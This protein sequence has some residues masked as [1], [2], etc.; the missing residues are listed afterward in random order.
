MIILRFGKPWIA[1]LIPDR[2]VNPFN[3]CCLMFVQGSRFWHDHLVNDA[4]P[5]VPFTTRPVYNPLKGL[6]RVVPK[7]S[8]TIPRNQDPTNFDIV[9]T[10]LLVIVLAGGLTLMEYRHLVAFLTLKLMFV[11]QKHA[12]LFRTWQ[13]KVNMFNKIIIFRESFSTFMP[14]QNRAS[15]CGQPNMWR[16]LGQWPLRH[17]D[18]GHLPLCFGLHAHW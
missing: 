13:R 16:F 5:R 2:P 12:T 4:C 18:A 17:Q 10:I 7:L 9:C 11:V 14:L 8:S 3:T 1:R 15:P 6:R